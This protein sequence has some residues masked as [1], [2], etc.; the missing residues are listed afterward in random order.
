MMSSATLGSL[1]ILML[2]WMWKEC[3]QH[4]PDVPRAAGK[5]Y[6]DCL[7]GEYRWCVQHSSEKGDE[8]T[9]PVLSGVS[10][11]VLEVFSDT[12]A[13][14]GLELGGW[15]IFLPALH[16]LSSLPSFLQLRLLSEA[17]CPD[18][19]Q[20]KCC[21]VPAVPQSYLKQLKTQEKNN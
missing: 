4:F 15:N 14:S 16:S 21:F 20:G 10:Q 5:P 18:L 9:A 7:V 1:T 17:Q 13:N 8:N 3:K 6:M 2:Q 19:V 12:T 11:R